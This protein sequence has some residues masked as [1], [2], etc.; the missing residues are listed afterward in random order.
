MVRRR[1][2]LRILTASAGAAVVGACKGAA[3]PGPA[4]PALDATA[5]PD[6]PDGGPGPAL[7]GGQDAASEQPGRDASSAA[8]PDC[9]AT[10]PDVEGPFFEAGA[11]QRTQLAAADEPGD[12]LRIEGT[13]VDQDCRP[14]AGVLLDVWQADRDGNYHDAGSEYR[15][16]AQLLTDAQG[17]YAFDSIVPGNYPIAEGSWRPAH[18]H[19]MVSKPGY[20]P[21][22]TQLYFQGDPYLPPNDG[23]GGCGSDDPAR[24]IALSGSASDGFRGDFQIAL[25]SA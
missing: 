17:R 23:C 15:L 9:P 5:P 7:H 6:V 24:I 13:V 8:E 25:A 16:R 4:E 12:R 1:S 10:T 11:P 18:V 22:T 2:F 21:L 14:V 19:F 3:T 20:L